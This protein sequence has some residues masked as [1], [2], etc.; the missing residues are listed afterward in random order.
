M[1]LGTETE[2]AVTALLG[3]DVVVP[4][5]PIGDYPF[6]FGVALFLADAVEKLG[7]RGFL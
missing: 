6:T 2:T 7:W 4:Y 3:A 1:L 5:A